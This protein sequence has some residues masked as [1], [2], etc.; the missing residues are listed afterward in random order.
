MRGKEKG[1]V[2]GQM[3]LEGKEMNTTSFCSCS[4][5]GEGKRGERRQHLGEIIFSSGR[6]RKRE[7]N[8][9][10]ISASC[11]Q[12]GKGKEGDTPLLNLESACLR[13]VLITH[14]EGEEEIVKLCPGGG[15]TSQIRPNAFPQTKEGGKG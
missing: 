12:R 13:N 11:S 10:Y 3:G 5:G 2:G 7:G 14:W 1:R 4:D 6:S 9:L 8:G 15:I